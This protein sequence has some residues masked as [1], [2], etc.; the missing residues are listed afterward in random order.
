MGA[1]PE[2]TYVVRAGIDLERYDPN[3]DGS[4]I[5]DR[6]RIK[7][8]DSVLFFMGWLYDFSGL[9]GCNRIIKDQG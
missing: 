3:I 9:K 7:E 1:N 2:E 8:D 5:R 4:E 6:Y